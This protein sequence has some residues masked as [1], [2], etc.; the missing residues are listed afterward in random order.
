MKKILITLLLLLALPVSAAPFTAV[1]QATSTTQ[2]E[3]SPLKINGTMPGLVFPYL[4]AT[5]TTATSTF[6]GQV[7]IGTSGLRILGNGVTSIASTTPWGLFSI[8][9][10]AGSPVNQFVVGSSTA[11][12]FLIGNNGN[13]SIGTT[14]AYAKLNI[15]G[16]FGINYMPSISTTYSVGDPTSGSATNDTGF[17][18]TANGYTHDYRIYAYRTVNGNTFFS[19][20]FS[21]ASF[22]DDG[23]GGFYIVHVTWP[24]VT[25]AT[26]YRLA[27]QDNV[28]NSA[29][30]GVSCDFTNCYIDTTGAGVFDG[31]PTQ[32]AVVV[33][34]TSYTNVQ[35]TT[36]N[37]YF[38][39]LLKTMGFGTSSPWAQ[40]SIN[41][42]N[43][44]VPAFVVGSSTATNFIVNNDGKV[45]VGTN[46]P[47]ATL[48]VKGST[49]GGTGRAF[50]ISDSANIERLRVQDNGSINR[51]LSS[52]LNWQEVGRSTSYIG[53]LG[54]ANDY[55]LNYDTSNERVCIGSCNTQP[56]SKLASDG[57]MTIGTGY[58]GTAAPTNGLLVQGKLGIGTSTPYSALSV[59]GTTTVSVLESTTTA[60]STFAG[61]VSS[62]C[63]TTDGSTCITASAGGGANSKWATSSTSIYPNAA[64]S[65]GIGTTSPW[66]TL[67][68]AG[69]SNGTVNLFNVSTSTASATSS[70]FVIDSTGRTGIGAT[71]SPSAMLAIRSNNTTTAGRALAI[72]NSL[73]TEVFKVDSTG[74][75]SIG[76]STTGATVRSVTLYSNTT[77]GFSSY[78]AASGG[79]SRQ[80][81]CTKSRGVLGTPTAVVAADTICRWFMQAYDGSAFQ[82]PADFAFVVGG[83]GVTSGAVPVDLVIDTGTGSSNRF[84]AMRVDY[85]QFVGIGTTTPN[86]FLGI[87]AQDPAGLGVFG[88][89]TLEVNGREDSAGNPNTGYLTKWGLYD[90]TNNSVRTLDVIDPAGKLGIGTTTTSAPL[91]VQ[92]D[93]F[94]GTTTGAISGIILE[95]SDASCHRITV[96]NI[97]VITAASVACPK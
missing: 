2:G 39:N 47:S 6:D 27:V 89:T 17:T 87:Q 74:Q 19:S 71:T 13:V 77:N 97:N 28:P 14:S 10:I 3:I 70:V 22:T 75:I 4:K 81:F 12:N 92:G 18:Y 21:T 63:F 41:P 73:G 7:R 79:T 96:S 86:A 33:T 91:T 15:A 69:A 46:T 59:V 90:V 43:L 62:T 80:D 11:T 65:V 93:V 85:R 42:N 61:A 5:S 49:S 95:A 53:F 64:T 32:G 34:P 16:D 83:G 54:N 29:G 84:E 37:V 52:T 40:V 58:L 50:V 1:W 82:L 48:S 72:S 94:L 23:L 9:P 78:V 57:N 8:N 60:T 44:T 56:S 20:G 66:A 25:N 26:G 30:V 45:G 51:Y 88:T 55:F 35:A 31:P 38:N 67:G 24:A 36:S 68:I 76:T